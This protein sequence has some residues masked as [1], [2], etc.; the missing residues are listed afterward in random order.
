MNT[1]WLTW[2]DLDR[3]LV[4]NDVI[5]FGSG[6]W[7]EKTI[8]KINK[9]PLFI[10]DNSEIMQNTKLSDVDIV[11]PDHITN[12]LNQNI[13]ILITTG[14]FETVVDQLTQMGYS[15][16]VHFFCSPV[17]FNQKIQVDIKENDQTL[18]FTCSNIPEPDKNC[19]GGGL[20]SFN[21]RTSELIKHISGKFHEIVKT[22]TKYYILDEFHG[23]K[24]FDKQLNYL[25]TY[26]GLPGSMMHGLS[27]DEVN[28][29][30]F[31][32]NTGRD[33]I[34]IIAAEDGEHLDE[35]F[36][37][38]KNIEGEA[39]R[40]HVNDLFF[41]KGDL[42]ISMFSFT[43]LWREG[44]YD[45][46]VA[47][48]DLVKKKISGYPIQNLWMP[49]SINFINGEIVVADSMNG[50]VYKTNNK[51]LVHLAGF[52][53]GIAYDGK[54]F[55]IGQSEH[56][57]FDRL[58]GINENISLNCGIHLYDDVNKASRFYS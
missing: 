38:K 24:V 46:G 49:H 32:A 28:N 36:I 47:K 13:I 16:A 23:V 10:L 42:Y 31:V 14:S 58:K 18:L 21:T 34:S 17:L 19:S 15:K 53:R 3:L 54:Y 20:Y 6:E 39:D 5:F 37:S 25:K 51:I 29:L 56:R 1:M 33:S 43:G 50:N 52:I 7:A 8:R 30:L 44:C 41:Y 55:Y 2:E 9:K 48:L 45:G 4:D 26:D 12:K 27:Y 35:I 57:Y 40:H 22:E 11:P